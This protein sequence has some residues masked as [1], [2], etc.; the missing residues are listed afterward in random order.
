[1]ASYYNVLRKCRKWYRK[2]ALSLIIDCSITNSW[3]LHNKK[4]PEKK[5]TMREF[6]ESI[7][8]DL[9]SKECERPR[10][11]KRI[12]SLTENGENKRRKCKGCYQQLRRTMGSREAD[13]KT[14]KVITFCEECEGKPAY[15]LS[16]FNECHSKLEK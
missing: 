3:I 2:L 7:C 11:P 9:L 16:C 8:K 4:F 1:M 14:K 5:L 12:H 15:C 6:R 10:T 13:N